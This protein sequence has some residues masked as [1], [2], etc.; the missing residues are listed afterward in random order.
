M[1]S[2]VVRGGL[3]LVGSVSG[4]V[5]LAAAMKMVTCQNSGSIVEPEGIRPFE[6]FLNGVPKETISDFYRGRAP[7]KYSN[8]QNYNEERAIRAEM[9]QKA[10]LWK[11]RP[12]QKTPV[13]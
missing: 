3:K 2:G 8:W 1:C 11:T 10:T 5:E 6:F 7:Y 4:E 13:E 9:D 12:C